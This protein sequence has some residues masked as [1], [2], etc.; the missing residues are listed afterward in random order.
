M[1]WNWFTKMLG[2]DEQPKR[3]KVLVEIPFEQHR[4]SMDD[5]S[6]SRLKFDADDNLP[7]DGVNPVDPEQEVD[8]GNK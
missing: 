6:R 4:F 1:M 2:R 5:F 7:Q 3:K 8:A